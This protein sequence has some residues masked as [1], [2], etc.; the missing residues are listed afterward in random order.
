MP[1]SRRTTAQ[2]QSLIEQHAQSSLSI[3]EFCK[4]KGL[5]ASSF[6][7]WRRKLGHQLQH[8]DFLELQPPSAAGYPSVTWRL[9][10]DLPGGGQL[11]LRFEP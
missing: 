9:E 2:W 6:H 4:K 5:S 11:R 7:R 10:V 1:V 8:S 3:A